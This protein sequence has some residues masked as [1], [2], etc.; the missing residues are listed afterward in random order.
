M[1]A[2]LTSMHQF[3]EALTR[4][5]P[6]DIR[7]TVTNEYL[8]EM[9][10]AVDDPAEVWR[11][12][13]LLCGR[14]ALELVFNAENDEGC[15][16]YREAYKYRRRAERFAARYGGHIDQHIDRYIDVEPCMQA[17]DWQVTW[18]RSINRRSAECFARREASER[19]LIACFGHIPTLEEYFDYLN[20]KTEAFEEI[21][22]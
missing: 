6:C 1:T 21:E 13:K 14:I 12:T 15:G 19:E 11:L 5:V 7:P 22:S 3:V 2:Q 10:E 17:A 16:H 8:Y 18:A 9:R 4:E 20:S